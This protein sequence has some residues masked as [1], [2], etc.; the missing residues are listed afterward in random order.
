MIRNIIP[1]IYQKNCPKIQPM[2]DDSSHG[3]IRSSNTLTL[4]PTRI[5]QS[6][7]KT[8][9]LLPI[10]VILLRLS[11]KTTR[12]RKRNPN[13]KNSS[14]HRIRKINTFTKLPSTNCKVNRTHLMNP[15]ILLNLLFFLLRAIRLLE[16]FLNIF[17]LIHDFILIPIREEII[18]NLITRKKH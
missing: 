9:L 1:F 2:S 8:H 18:H 17:D 16:N 10:Q 3:L 15:Y 12:I 4:K 5:I 14:C 6:L 7:S 11:F 13:N